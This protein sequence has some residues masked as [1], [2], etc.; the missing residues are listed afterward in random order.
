[1]FFKVWKKLNT[2][3]LVAVIL[4]GGGYA[5]SMLKDLNVNG[6]GIQG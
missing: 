6:A 4:L 1:M 5:A 2:V 3:I